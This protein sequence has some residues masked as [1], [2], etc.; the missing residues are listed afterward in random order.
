M[1]KMCVGKARKYFLKPFFSFN[2]TFFKVSAQ[3][4][5]HHVT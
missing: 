5:C 1:K 4:L 3:N 2:K